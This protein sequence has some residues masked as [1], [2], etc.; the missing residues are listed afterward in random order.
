VLQAMGLAR[1]LAE[2]SV[3]FSFGKDNTEADIDYAAAAY[4]KVIERLRSMSPL[5]EEYQRE[6]IDSIIEP[7]P[8]LGVGNVASA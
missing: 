2:A 8:P 4:A 7:R 1:S 6:R 3:I 5:W